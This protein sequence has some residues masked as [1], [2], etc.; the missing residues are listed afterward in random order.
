MEMGSPIGQ[1]RTRSAPN[2]RP[3]SPHSA[4]RPRTNERSEGSIRPLGRLHHGDTVILSVSVLLPAAPSL[5]EVVPVTMKE[6]TPA[7]CPLTTMRTVFE[8]ASAID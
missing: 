2:S 3:S 1:S 6:L 4:L 7:D 5:L 8:P